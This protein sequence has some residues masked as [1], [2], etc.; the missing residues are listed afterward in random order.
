MVT[1]FSIIPAFLMGSVSSYG[2]V[3]RLRLLDWY[4]VSQL[5]GR[6]G[7]RERMV[8]A[9]AAGFRPRRLQAGNIGES[10]AAYG[11]PVLAAAIGFKWGFWTFGILLAL[12]LVIFIAMARNAPNRGSAKSFSE[13]VQHLNERSSNNVNNRLE[14][15]LFALLQS[16]AIPKIGLV[17]AAF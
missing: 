5:F 9:G 11:S 12:W 16:A 3:T 10:L 6:S 4:R 2:Q 13:I 17:P 1:V 14:L 7:I 15:L 8:S